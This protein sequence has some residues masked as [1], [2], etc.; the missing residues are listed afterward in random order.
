MM[1]STKKVETKKVFAVDD[2]GNRFQIGTAIV[3]DKG[4][5]RIAFDALPMSGFAIV[6]KGAK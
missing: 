5:V 4:E 6:E 1:T 2:E 3:D